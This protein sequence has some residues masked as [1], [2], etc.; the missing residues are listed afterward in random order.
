MAC[1]LTQGY[2]N[3]CRDS[4]GGAKE[5]MI[6]EF[7][8][9]ADITVAAGIVTAIENASTKRWWKYKPAKETASGK[10]TL[11]TN[12]QNGTKF[13]AQEVVMAL[14][15]LQTNTRLELDKL[16]QNTLLVVVKDQNDKNWLYG[17]KNGLDATAGE[18]GTGTAMG[19]RNGYTVTLT[20]QEPEDAIEVDAATYATL[21]TPGT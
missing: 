5:V 2:T 21:E 1:A 3:D 12:V 15:K 18:S 10:A 4:A 8:N 13:Y 6:I 11:N 20:G 9:V 19:D 16:A 7:A 17:Y 14:N